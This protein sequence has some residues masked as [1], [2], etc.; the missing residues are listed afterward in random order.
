[1]Q[2]TREQRHELEAALRGG[3]EV[4]CPACGGRVS[5]QAVPVPPAVAYVRARIWIVCL[6]CKRSVSVDRR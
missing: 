3:G 5:V 6:D 1:M 2:Y 4:K